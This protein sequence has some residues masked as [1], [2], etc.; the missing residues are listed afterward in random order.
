VNNVVNNPSQGLTEQ[1]LRM[2]HGSNNNTPADF[3]NLPSVHSS[4][5]ASGR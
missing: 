5:Y 3:D 4:E 1:K 2:L